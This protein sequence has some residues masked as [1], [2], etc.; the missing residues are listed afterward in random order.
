[1]LVI[2]GALSPAGRHVLVN[3]NIWQE[4]SR[5]KN[6]ITL[7][8]PYIMKRIEGLH[9]NVL[10]KCNPLNGRACTLKGGG[11]GCGLKMAGRRRTIKR[12]TRVRARK[13]TKRERRV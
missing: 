12:S 4:V 2:F 1:M 5:Q 8:S 6:V 10:S 7:L 9:L 13:R 11:G 3:K